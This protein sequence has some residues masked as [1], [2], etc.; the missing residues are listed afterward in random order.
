MGTNLQKSES[1]KKTRFRG[2]DAVPR[3]FGEGVEGPGTRMTAWS[4]H[5]LISAALRVGVIVLSRLKKGGHTTA[6]WFFGGE[7]NSA[8]RRN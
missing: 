8:T 4:A 7:C 1:I 2:T 6:V 5:S 3:A